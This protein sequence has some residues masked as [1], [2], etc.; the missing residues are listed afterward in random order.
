MLAWTL[1]HMASGEI[2]TAKDFLHAVGRVVVEEKIKS[3]VHEF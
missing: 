1:A 2:K 3:M